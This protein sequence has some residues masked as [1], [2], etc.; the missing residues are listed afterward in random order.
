MADHTEAAAILETLDNATL[1][2]LKRRVETQLM[3]R[4]HDKRKKRRC[5]VIPSKIVHNASLKPEGGLLDKGKCSYDCTAVNPCAVAA[6]VK[7]K[8]CK[9]A[10]LCA[11]HGLAQMCEFCSSVGDCEIVAGICGACDAPV[12]YDCSMYVSGVGDISKDRMFCKPC[13]AYMFLSF[14]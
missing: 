3:K 2:S 1:L 13:G 9:T 10:C 8:R 14:E 4:A 7:C 11:E 6:T 12:C 5:M